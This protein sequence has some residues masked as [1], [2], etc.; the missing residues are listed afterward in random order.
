MPVKLRDRSDLSA[1]TAEFAATTSGL[2]INADTLKFGVSTF[3]ELQQSI[4][5][6]RQRVILTDYAEQTR[7][8]TRQRR[9]SSASTF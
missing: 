9:A 7:E 4:F 5:N 3:S 8:D 2:V 6:L 1:R